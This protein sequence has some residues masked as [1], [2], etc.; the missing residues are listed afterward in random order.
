M[1]DMCVHSY[2]RKSRRYS[3]NIGLAPF[4]LTLVF[5]GIRLYQR[6]QPEGAT[7]GL[8]GDM[9]VEAG[10]WTT[11]VGPYSRIAV[12]ATILFFLV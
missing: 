8:Q 1:A 2:K 6:R 11:S 12:Q 3:G 5:A 7:G 10:I 4:G 9:Q